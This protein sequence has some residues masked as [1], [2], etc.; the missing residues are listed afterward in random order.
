MNC[1]NA[2]FSYEKLHLKKLQKYIS[3]Q[4]C[5]IK[6]IMTDI[7]VLSKDEKGS[8]SLSIIVLGKAIQN[9]V[10][11]KLGIQRNIV[12]KISFPLVSPFM[13]NLVVEESI[14]RLVIDRLI[15]ENNTP[16][17]VKYLG[18]LRCMEG[19]TFPAE[20]KD[21]VMDFL[22]KNSKK[23]NV[24]S[25]VILFTEMANG[26][27]LH[28]WLSKEEQYI[29]D[30]IAV[31]FQLFYTLK[32][33]QRIGLYHNDMHSGNIFVEILPYPVTMFFDTEIG[34]IELT[35]KFIP[36]I[37]DYDLSAIFY[38]GIER[39]LLLDVGLCYDETVCN[40]PSKKRDTFI[41]LTN[42]I[43]VFD[44][45]SFVD[46]LK[47]EIFSDICDYEWVKKAVGTYIFRVEDE[48]RVSELNTIMKVLLKSAGSPLKKRKAPPSG[49]V[50]FT[51]PPASEVKVTPVTIVKT[52][53]MKVSPYYDFIDISSDEDK[54]I[55]TMYS[56]SNK[57]TGELSS[58]ILK[59]DPKMKNVISYVSEL[60]LSPG[61]Y[62]ISEE[63]RR[64]VF[65]HEILSNLYYALSLFD[66]KLPVKGY[67]HTIKI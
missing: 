66:W 32:C 48:K 53:K 36:K 11:E 38:D 52:P 57:D 26:S 45:Y 33:F 64:K 20:S 39:N 60:L 10:E 23:I 17:L 56:E 67:V 21:I 5:D 29:E 28:K 54:L 34:V 58:L 62:D 14:Y 12:I 1:S 27:T 61:F 13:N 6:K 47:K 42:L 8:V 59:K 24:E 50:I 9:K 44:G 49:A 65:R 7:K 55:Y 19:I 31:L 15:K 2:F 63:T 46:T 25:P 51:L 18:T 3:E 16:C 41:L 4:T 30:I 22:K 37:Y 43:A 40:F 35:T